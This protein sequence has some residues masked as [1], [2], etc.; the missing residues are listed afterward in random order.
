MCESTV[1]SHGARPIDQ[2][3]RAVRMVEMAIDPQFIS[4]A[5]VEDV[6]ALGGEASLDDD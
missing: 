6:A 1:G 3:A 5:D 2:L 4:L